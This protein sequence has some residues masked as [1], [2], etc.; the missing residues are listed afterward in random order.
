MDRDLP[1]FRELS[2]RDRAWIGMVA[3]SGIS[4]FVDWFRESD[5][6]P[7]ALRADV[8]SGKDTTMAVTMYEYRVPIT[9]MIDFRDS[10]YQ[11]TSSGALH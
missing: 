11:A 6:E 5:S 10:L 4:S 2:A 7:K 8:K 3:Q 1:W 9:D